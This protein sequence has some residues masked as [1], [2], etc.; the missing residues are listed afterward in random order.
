M[1][2]QQGTKHLGITLADMEEGKKQRPALN[3]TCI[4]NI[5]G[6][7]VYDD[8][9]GKGFGPL[10]NLDSSTGIGFVAIVDM[11]GGSTLHFHP[12]STGDKHTGTLGREWEAVVEHSSRG[13]QAYYRLAGNSSRFEY[14]F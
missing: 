3:H 7:K 2:P 5:E 14:F 13:R 8:V 11:L 1:T 10:Y 12:E 4:S 6:R 9:G